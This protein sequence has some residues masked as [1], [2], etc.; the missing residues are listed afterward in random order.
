MSADRLRAR[1]EGAIARAAEADLA[2]LLVT[3]GSDLAYLIGYDP[4]PLERMTL[5]VLVPD[6]EP[7][8]LVPTLERP[9]ALTAP[10]A[11]AVEVVGWD[12]G[13]DPYA[14][15]GRLLSSGGRLAI[16]DQAW[17]AHVL[18]LQRAAPEASFTTIGAALPLLRAVKDEDELARLRG[19]GAAA[20]AAFADIVRVRFE[21]RSELE[22]AADLADALRAHGHQTVDFTIVGSGPNGASPHHDASDRTIRAGE[23]VVLDFGGHMAGYCSDTTRTVVVREPSDELRRVHEVVQ[24]AQ[25]A[26]VDAVRPG[27]VCEAV[28][29]AARAVIEDAG[30]GE[31]F[32]HRTGHGI[33][34]DV[35]E[36]PYIVSGDRTPLQPG[37]TF[38]VEPGIYLP[39]RFGV[40]IEDIVAVT[41]DGGE[42]FNDSP[43]ELT[44]VA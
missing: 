2:G 27:V 36:P 8:L 32:I 21:G 16:S 29:A 34:L 20:D 19:V 7:V 6:R 38:S 26:G 30:Y 13:D 44:V 28:D 22:V 33:G 1:I 25:R 17:A 24:T 5:L 23:A 4:L 3:P 18:G 10:G 12:E 15:A 9:A 14:A 40:R 37:M 43:H 39:N 35:H 42:R 11:G 41:P 31:R